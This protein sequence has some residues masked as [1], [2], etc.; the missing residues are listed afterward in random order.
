MICID[1]QFLSP[2]TADISS[3]RGFLYGDGFF[4]SMRIREKI[5]AF[6]EYHQQRFLKSLTLLGFTNTEDLTNMFDDVYKL[7]DQLKIIDNGRIRASIYRKSSGLYTPAD[8]K[9][10]YIITGSSLEND[11]Q[12]NEKGL[13]I[14]F[15]N[16]QFKMPGKYS[17]IKSLSSQLYVMAAM[18]A[19]KHHLDEVI[20]CN[21]LSNGIE[22]NTS[23]IFIAKNGIIQTSPLSEGA[24]DGV[25]R[26]QLIDKLHRH[27]IKLE[28]LPLTRE[29]ITNADE[30]WFCN[31]V[32]GLR[33]VEKLSNGTY[34]NTI[35]QKIFSLH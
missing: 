26:R 24:V 8:N 29:I 16:E 32:R 9:F 12:L 15:Y 27:T 35:A 28:E 34:T 22:G 14:D 4:E 3:N 18:Y 7:I 25:F 30:I 33:W 23:N 21:H 20:I 5:I 17:E 11:Y 13:T 1:G 19:Q 31:A 10:G 2:E 6:E